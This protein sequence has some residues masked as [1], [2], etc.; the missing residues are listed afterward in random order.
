MKILVALTRVI[1]CNV[2]RHVIA[3]DSGVDLVDVSM[4]INARDQIALDKAIRLKDANAATEIMAV[5][6]GPLQAQETLCTALV[7][8]ADS[9]VLIATDGDVEPLAVANLLFQLID[10]ADTAPALVILGTSAIDDVSTQTGQML[11]VLLGWPQATFASK[12][13][14]EGDT[15]LVTREVDGR[16][17]TVRLALPAVVMTHPNA[18]T[19]RATPLP[20]IMKANPPATGGPEGRGIDTVARVKTFKVSEPPLRRARIKMAEADALVATLKELGV[21]L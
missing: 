16:L 2:K 4:S 11:A 18:T 19:S 21:A 15:L 5:S 12:V 6:V 1:D 10:D 8:G 17:E 14:H 20:K 3:H 9:A 13:D 7:M